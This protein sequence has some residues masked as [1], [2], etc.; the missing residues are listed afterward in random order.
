MSIQ[1]RNDIVVVDMDILGLATNKFQVQGRSSFDNYDNYDSN[2]DDD[3]EDYDSRR[4][5]VEEVEED[6][7]DDPF[8]DQKRWGRSSSGIIDPENDAW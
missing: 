5:L 6:D 8:S 7:D 1:V 3:K 2:D 4:S